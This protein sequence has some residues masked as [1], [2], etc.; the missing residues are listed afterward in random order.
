MRASARSIALL[1][2]SLAACSAE[3][4]HP[5]WVASSSSGA[6]FPM[7]PKAEVGRALATLEG[8]VLYETACDAARIVQLRERAPGEC[9]VVE[10]TRAGAAPKPLARFRGSPFAVAVQGESVYALVAD[11]GGP[12][13]KFRGQPSPGRVVEITSKGARTLA[14]GFR[15]R[16]VFAS[17]A[18]DERRV[19]WLGQRAEDKP[20]AATF[21]ARSLDGQERFQLPLEGVPGQ[22]HLA[23]DAALVFAWAGSSQ[24]DLN[25]R[26]AAFQMS[27]EYRA[28]AFKGRDV[29]AL[30]AL[31]LDHVQLLET[32]AKPSPRVVAAAAPPLLGEV[33][34]P[35]V[36]PADAACVALDSFG[37][38][39][40]KPGVWCAP[41]AGG[42]FRR[43][44]PLAE[45]QTAPTLLGC[46][47]DLVWIDAGRKDGRVVQTV[48]ALDL[49][50]E[51]KG[52]APP[53]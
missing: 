48:R 37:K 34:S 15:V 45:N 47:D 22:I 13:L 52:E 21:F 26:T 2:A 31:D 25:A 28:V 24:I 9:E 46:G 11:L 8:D 3:P 16:D 53:P 42:E 44:I 35:L 27:M 41:R 14:D 17:L 23:G 50:G 30:R 4:P 1:L 33:G 20:D 6:P 36:L 29:F 39:A 19:T 49:K 18:V 7:A 40:W 12:S 43:V 32:T 38:S 51:L 10:L 5:A